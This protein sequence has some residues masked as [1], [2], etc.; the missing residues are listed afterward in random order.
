MNQDRKLN[1]WIAFAS[2]LGVVFGIAL[3]VIGAGVGVLSF[4]KIE[5]LLEIEDLVFF[6]NQDGIYKMQT[7]LFNGKVFELKYLYAFS[8][9][10]VGVIGLLTLIFAAISLSYAKKRKVVRRRLALMCYNLVPLAVAACTIVYLV[11]E[12][13]NLSDN[14]KYV[15][16]GL[17]GVFSLIALCNILGI[18]FG[19][20]E[21]FMS[22]DNSKYAFD[23]AGIKNARVSINN[24]VKDAEIAPN[25]Y[26]P[27]EYQPQQRIIPQQVKQH[28]QQSGVIR[29][30]QPTPNRM[31]AVRPTTS[32]NI[33]PAGVQQR[34]V[35][36]QQRPTV[37]RPSNP[38]QAQRPA[39]ARPSQPVRS[40]QPIRPTQP[41]RP[42]QAP[43]PAPTSAVKRCP[44]CGKIL[45]PGEIFCSMCGA[46]VG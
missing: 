5:K 29:P 31:G 22:N 19:R 45:K 21:Q 32:S 13:D 26:Q 8:G 46:R 20:S 3:I 28:Q 36:P 16:Y 18:I 39:S 10:F 43:R 25:E 30:T 2:I 24:N 6:L 27:S 44:K 40:A 38:A 33:R 9:V 23:N 12:F 42:A 4:I 15:G 34:P 1:G 37:T 14:I 41:V 35:Q 7:S 11:L 17:A